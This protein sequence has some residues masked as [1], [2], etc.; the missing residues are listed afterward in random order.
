MGVSAKT[1]EYNG[2]TWVDAND[3]D[4]GKRW[5]S[6]TG[7]QTAVIATGGE[8]TTTNCQ[9]YDGTNWA[10]GG[11]LNTGR[12]S[13]FAF[14]TQTNT[15]VMGTSSYGTSSEQYNG[16]AWTAVDN[17]PSGKYLGAS[18]GSAG[19]GITAG[20]QRTNSSTYLTDTQKYSAEV[21]ARTVTDS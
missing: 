17:H 21:T 10:S 5:H 7:T 2:T 3:M 12:N 13:H 1:E 6:A 20:G 18:C 19:T 11:T 9:E 16:T 4:A 14:G 15:I 8:G